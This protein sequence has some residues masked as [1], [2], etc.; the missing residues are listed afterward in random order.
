MHF[1]DSSVVFFH[2]CLF[3]RPEDIK[4]FPA[5][6]SEQA[7]L[8]GGESVKEGLVSLA[9]HFDIDADRTRRNSHKDIVSSMR[10]TPGDTVFG[11]RLSIALYAWK[12]M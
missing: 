1:V 2:E 11:K 10:D 12:K 7:P 5:F 4:I 9:N 3:G 8:L 6:L